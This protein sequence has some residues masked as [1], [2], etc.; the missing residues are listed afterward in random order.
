MFEPWDSEEKIPFPSGVWELCEM[1]CHVAVVLSFLKT[2]ITGEDV[3]RAPQN[4]RWKKKKMNAPRRDP[5][6]FRFWILISFVLISVQMSG[7]L[8]VCLGAFR[9]YFKGRSSIFLLLVYLAGVI[10]LM[11]AVHW[12]CVYF[13]LTLKVWFEKARN[14]WEG[15]STFFFEKSKYGWLMYGLKENCSTSCSRHYYMKTTGL[16]Y[17]AQQVTMITY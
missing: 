10:V 15:L 4:S 17:T 12:K 9:Y 11:L 7:M 2:L 8:L 14:V 1:M 13:N 5:I 16:S 3:F 6:V